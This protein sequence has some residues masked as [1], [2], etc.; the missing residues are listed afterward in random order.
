MSSSAPLPALRAE[1]ITVRYS[2]RVAVHQI[3]F[4]TGPG[5]LLAIAGPNGSGKTTLIRAL[6]GLVAPEQGQAWVGGLRVDRLRM[7]ERARAVAWLPQEEPL[8]DNVPLFE[9]VLYGRHPHLPPFTG[10]SGQDR[11]AA[12]DALTEMDLWDRRESGVW[13]LSGGE[14]QRL[15]LARV[16]AQS[17]PVVI[18]DEPTVHLDIA[19]QLDLLERLRRL[20]H[21]D[22][23]CV[24]TALHDLNLAARYADRVLVLHRGRL[25]AQGEPGSV[26][27]PAL[28]QDV[29]GIVADLRRDARTGVPYLIPSLPA[30]RGSDLMRSAGLGTVH[31]VGGG[32]AATPLIRRLVDRGYRVTAGILPLFDTDTETAQELGLAVATEVPFA[33]LGAQA[34]REHRKLLESASSIVVAPFAVGEGNIAN[35]EDLRPYV[36]GRPTY[37]LGAR[38]IADRDFVSGRAVAALQE[39]QQLGAHMVDDIAEILAALER[40][41]PLGSAD[42]TLPS[43]GTISSE[44]GQMGDG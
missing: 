3:S 6:T 2:D 33:E 8:G 12:Q 31:V 42:A 19:H 27:S 43:D 37:L 14:R 9:Y 36:P 7:L 24:V 13:E 1:G 39:L 21:R 20:A 26:L 4:E 28:L 17:T 29:W 23:R 30:E 5:E 41:L 34:R 15:R 10:E 38:T 18:L 40:A 11:R 32:G 16:F 25:V 35:L 44:V 22:R